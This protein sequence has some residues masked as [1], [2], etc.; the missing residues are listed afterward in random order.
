MLLLVPAYLSFVSGFG[1]GELVVK[2]RHVV[3]VA[4]A[5]SLSR[6]SAS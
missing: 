1:F 6:T 4:F 2:P 3:L 5:S